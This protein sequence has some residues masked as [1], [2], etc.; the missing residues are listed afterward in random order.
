MP[1][2]PTITTYLEPNPI[3]P[4]QTLR[5]RFQLESSQQTKV[6]YIEATLEGTES[7]YKRTVSS[8]KS[9]R[10]VYHRRSV[11]SLAAR[12]PA[13][14]LE[15]GTSEH[16]V[17]FDVP[18]DAPPSYRSALANIHY[19]LT[20]RVSIPWWPD[21]VARYDITV[22]APRMERVASRPLLMTSNANESRGKDPLI[23]LSTNTSVLEPGAQFDASIALD[24]AGDRKIDRVELSLVAIETARVTSSAGPTEVDRRRWALCATAPKDGAASAARLVVPADVLRGFTSPFIAVTHVLEARAVVSWGSD[25]VLSA[26]VTVVDVDAPQSLIGAPLVGRARHSEVWRAA[27]AHLRLPGVTDLRMDADACE[28]RFTVGAVNAVVREETHATLGPCVV[29]ELSYGNLGLDLRVV[30]R[31]WTDWGSKF[32]ELGS[33]FRKRFSCKI[34]DSRQLASLLDEPLQQSLLLFDEVGLSDEG[35]IALR[36][37]GVYQPSSLDRVLMLVHGLAYRLD[38]S[39][40]RVAPPPAFAASLPRWRNFAATH[41]ASLRAG[42]LAV[43]GW[44][45]RGHSLSIVHAFDGAEPAYTMIRAVIAPRGRDAEDGAALSSATGAT[46]VVH[47]GTVA[48]RVA[49]ALEPSACVEPADRLAVAL[50]ALLTGA[51]GAYR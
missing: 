17:N 10:R 47:E 28:A 23:E 41:N 11:V 20:V 14:T 30:E 5:V 4:G 37:G 12:S 2:R 46:V 50:S 7:R 15:V 8:G 13:T 43:T 22:A 18:I 24:G 9:S 16:F 34:R 32:P 33:A 42:D 48:M 27:R 40:R 45:V 35:S 36:K 1:S 6:D 21:A 25:L 26:P 38:A 3:G 44:V 49:L 39:I 51:S 19:S 29:A 31:S